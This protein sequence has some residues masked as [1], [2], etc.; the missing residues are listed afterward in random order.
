MPVDAAPDVTWIQCDRCQTIELI[1]EPERSSRHDL[2]A[3]LESEGWSAEHGPV[4]CP[5]CVA[6]SLGG[7]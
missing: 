7:S 5:D 1:S 3:F 4:S 2:A 6:E